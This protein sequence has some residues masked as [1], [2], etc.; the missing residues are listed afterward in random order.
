MQ[1]QP[2]TVDLP[3]G[4]SARS[5]DGGDSIFRARPAASKSFKLS[6]N[7]GLD[8]LSASG[9]APTMTMVN[10]PRGSWKWA[11]ASEAV[12]RNVSSNFLVSSR[13]TASRPVAK[14]FT[15]GLE[16]GAEAV[17]RFE[18]DG[19]SRL[20][21]GGSED[22]ATLAGAAR[23]EA[24][25]REFAHREA[26][27]DEGGDDGGGAGNRDDREAG[28]DRGGDQLVAGITDAGGARLGDEGDVAC[29]ERGEELR[30]AAAHVVLVVADDACADAVLAEED[31]RCAGVFGGD[32]RRLHEGRGGRAG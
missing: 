26:R 5:G 21:R 22:A 8:A 29:L 18:E 23:E 31:A 11:S 19:R 12:P 4:Q 24:E 9:E 15:D 32:E 28:G 1:F 25:E 20:A 27:G 14:R 3:L 16:G 7:F 30:S 6:T 13:Q 10:S 2:Q 17:G